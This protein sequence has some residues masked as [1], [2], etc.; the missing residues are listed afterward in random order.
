MGAFF[1]FL[2]IPIPLS[3]GNFWCGANAFQRINELPF[4]F[5][6]F[7]FIIFFSSSFHSAARNLHVCSEVMLLLIDYAG[8]FAEM[9]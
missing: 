8:G 7:F 6:S 3:D 5:S 9:F 1:F 4:L 2:F